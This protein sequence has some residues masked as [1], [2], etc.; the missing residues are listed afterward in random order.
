LLEKYDGGGLVASYYM[1]LGTRSRADGAGGWGGVP[2]GI[3]FLFSWRSTMGC[4][5]PTSGPSWHVATFLHLSALGL[6]LI[7]LDY[8]VVLFNH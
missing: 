3:G 2:W 8:E 4:S 5:W 7:L 1:G 6:A